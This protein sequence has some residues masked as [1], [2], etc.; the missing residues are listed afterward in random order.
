MNLWTLRPWARLEA[1]RVGWRDG[2][3]KS[4]LKSP[5]SAG[6]GGHVPRRGGGG[7][8]E[9]QGERKG[10][11]LHPDRLSSEP[12]PDRLREARLKKARRQEGHEQ[13]EVQSCRRQGR[14]WERE[15]Q[16]TKQARKKDMIKIITQNC[17]LKSKRRFTVFI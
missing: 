15:G 4:P 5:L 14:D 12:G 1:K 10:P 16:G 6:Q 8:G 3:L 11:D 17:S 9:G 7:R 2:E 13:T